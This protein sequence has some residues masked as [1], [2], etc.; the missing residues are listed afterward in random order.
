MRGRINTVV[1]QLVVEGLRR[2]HPDALPSAPFTDAMRGDPVGVP[3]EPYRAFLDEAVRLGG[4]RCLLGAGRAL[5]GL[6]DPILFVLL[7]SESVV[8]LIEKELRLSRFIHSRHV[9]RIDDQAEN[10]I[11]LVHTSA[12]DDP[13]RATEDLAGAGQHISLLEQI[14]CRQLELRFPESDAPERA[15]YQ[16]GKY[17]EPAA[18]SCAT[19]A[20]S[21]EAFVPTRRPMP[22]LDELL[23]QTDPR[24]PL[25]E[26]P[27]I[28]TSI[29]SLALEDL[30][31]TWTLAEVA[32][33]LETST[34]SLQ[35]A[36]AAEQTRFS[37][38]LDQLRTREAARLL[39]QS[40]LSITD[41]G[42]VC[43]FADTSHFSRRFKRRHQVSPSDYRS[44]QSARPLDSPT[45]S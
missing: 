38:V 26:A 21:W 45:A 39:A 33:K 1:V 4:R 34:R 16:G 43:G 42:Y 17:I 28:V 7:N 36:L 29:E 40:D 3:L 11:T 32:H 31:R 14:G 22:G 23:T 6:S 5:E 37:E 25:T 41:I 30:G 27:A 2:F 12:A 19:W 13:P 24:A 9:V 18:G 10:S 35:R 44:N 15:V 20:F 8:V